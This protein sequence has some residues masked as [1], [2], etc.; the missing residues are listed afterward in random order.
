MK[1]SIT[2]AVT[3]IIAGEESKISRGIRHLGATSHSQ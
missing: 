3:A 1:V 2:T